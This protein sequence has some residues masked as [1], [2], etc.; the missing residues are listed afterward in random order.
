MAVSL[1][2]TSP[3]TSHADAGGNVGNISLVP[4]RYHTIQVST[5]GTNTVTITP[6]GVQ[7]E[8]VKLVV[9]QDMLEKSGGQL[10]SSP[11]E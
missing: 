5:D 1:V 6:A 3:T 11:S 10:Q 7:N 9:T 2:R 4:N 8:T